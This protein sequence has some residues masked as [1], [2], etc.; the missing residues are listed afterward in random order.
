MSGDF[1]VFEWRVPRDGF[2]W[3]LAHPLVGHRVQKERGR[4][5]APGFTMHWQPTFP[6][7]DA[8]ALFRVF[9]ETEPTEAQVLRF[10]NAYGALGIE[11]D[12]MLADGKGSRGERLRIW[13]QGIAHMRHAVRVW[14]ALCQ[15]ATADLQRWF[16]LAPP[17][18]GVSNL[19]Y[20]PDEPWPAGVLQ[21]GLQ[22]IEGELVG[23]ARFLSGAAGDPT[24][25]PIPRDA[26]GL[27]LAWLRSIINGRLEQHTSARMLYVDSPSGLGTHIV[28]RNLLGA[29]WL[30][31]ALA[32]EGHRAYRR[33]AACQSW[34]EVS[35]AQTGKRADAKFCSAR[36][37]VR[38]YRRGD[39]RTA[40]PA[41]KRRQS[42]SR[43]MARREQQK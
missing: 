41:N 36:C 33:C 15:K 35:T 16:T 14:D 2:T 1:T 26:P 20:T 18:S 21:S 28:P 5:L 24:H 23:I 34:F 7:R 38:A 31:F 32:I 4:F 10:A 17:F 29:L 13:V 11:E 27:A 9:A 6:L 40:R 30:Q 8:P 22:F 37:R 25:M 42:S 12:L 43:K 39:T 3:S 19:R